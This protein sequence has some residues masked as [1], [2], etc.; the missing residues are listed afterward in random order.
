MPNASA[1]FSKKLYD[2]VS[3]AHTDDIIAQTVERLA[4]ALAAA[5]GAC[6]PTQSTLR[7]SGT[8]PVQSRARQ[9][10]H[11]ADYEGVAK[12]LERDSAPGATTGAFPQ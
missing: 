10:E 2:V 4:D 6:T 12:T 9:A 11:F 7:S 1:R 8:D 5:L 3:A